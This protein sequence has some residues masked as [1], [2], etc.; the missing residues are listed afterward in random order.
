MDFAAS[1]S[2]HGISRE[3]VLHALRAVMAQQDQ[4]FDGEVRRLI[5]GASITG[6]LL[7]VVY[8]PSRDPALVIHADRLRPKFFFLID[9]R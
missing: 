7:E 3:D 9:Q 8:L 2:K 1:A 5:V 6:V 4:Y